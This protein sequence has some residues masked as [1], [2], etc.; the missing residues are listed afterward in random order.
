MGELEVLDLRLHD[1]RFRRSFRRMAQVVH[2]QRKTFHD[3]CEKW[4]EVEGP[5][6]PGGGQLVEDILTSPVTDEFTNARAVFL[7][8]AQSRLRL[9]WRKVPEGGWLS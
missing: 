7:G 5:L 8:A 4:D 2:T 1:R 9:T 3:N 6:S